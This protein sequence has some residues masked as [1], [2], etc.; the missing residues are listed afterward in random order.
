M[1]A[2]PLIRDGFFE[3]SLLAATGNIDEQDCKEE[4]NKIFIHA[5]A[6][7]CSV[8]APNVRDDG[9]C[10]ARVAALNKCRRRSRG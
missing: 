6:N 7:L 5:K 10:S 4:R 1:G 9:H 3:K 2:I 8:A